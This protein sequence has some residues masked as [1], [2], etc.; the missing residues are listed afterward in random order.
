M[1]FL[2]FLVSIL[3][4]GTT[5]SVASQDPFPGYFT[6]DENPTDGL[7]PEPIA[8]EDGENNA[9]QADGIDDGFLSTSDTVLWVLSDNSPISFETSGDEAVDMDFLASGCPSNNRLGARDGETSCTNP[10]QEELKTP[11]LPTYED[12]M[13]AV[14]ALQ[15]TQEDKVCPPPR[16]FHLCCDCQGWNHFGLCEDCKYCKLASIHF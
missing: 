1:Q 12:M 13:R 4:A 2:S 14:G 10:A 15:E 11:T 6:T 5:I 8:L 9:Q 7:G 3:F 16:L